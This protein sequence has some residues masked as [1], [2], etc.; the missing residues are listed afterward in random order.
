MEKLKLV[1]YALLI[2]TTLILSVVVYLGL[3]IIWAM[4]VSLYETF[5]TKAGLLKL[6][7][8]LYYGSAMVLILDFTS[9]S[10]I[11]LEGIDLVAFIL[12]VL[13]LKPL[14]KSIIKSNPE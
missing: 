4:L 12:M 11:A 10:P 5:F 6:I 7:D 9:I 8:A 13:L 3:K 14:E 1:L 2:V